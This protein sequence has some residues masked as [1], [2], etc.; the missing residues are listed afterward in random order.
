MDDSVEYPLTL[1][2][3]GPARSEVIGGLSRSLARGSVAT[4]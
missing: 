4:L 2:L 3:T 1:F